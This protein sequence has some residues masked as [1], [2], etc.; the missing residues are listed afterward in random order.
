MKRSFDLAVALAGLVITSPILALSAIAVKLESRGPAFFHGPRVGRH[1]RLFYIHKLRTMRPGADRAGPAVTAGDDP[2]VTRV[3]RFLRR[4]KL[5]ELP[6]LL[7]VVKGEMSLVGPRPEH[8]TYVERYTA[9]QRRLLA[10][11]PGITG[12]AAI[13]FIDEEEQLRGGQSEKVYVEEVMPKKLALELRYIDNAS[14][15]ADF[16]ILLKT[17]ATVIRRPFAA[18]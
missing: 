7:N 8:P 12:P 5:D 11:R 14:F 16:E 10:V 4:T 6:Q 2:R 15:R 1:G 3:G 17:A 18:S 9:E 13:A